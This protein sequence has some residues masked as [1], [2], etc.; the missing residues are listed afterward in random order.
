MKKIDYIFD[1]GQYRGKSIYD[2]NDPKYI[3]WLITKSKVSKELK[4]IFKSFMENGEIL[5]YSLNIKTSKLKTKKPIITIEIPDGVKFD[6]LEI[7][8]IKD[9]ISYKINKLF[10]TI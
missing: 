2:I 1:F 7:V 5:E 9:Q 8:I 4:K 10:K 3:E 6:E